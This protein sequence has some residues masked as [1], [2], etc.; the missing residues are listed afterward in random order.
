[1]R[2]LRSLRGLLPQ[3]DT[4][5]HA[6]WRRRHHAMVVL[7]FAEAVGLTLFSAVQGYGVLHSVAHVAT[8]V[9]VGIGALLL[10]HRRRIAS[11]LV[12]LG[13]ITACALL[14]HVWNGAIEA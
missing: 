3:G 12:S 7:L 8:L 6:A 9:P 10:E 11:I 13:L 2:L 5:P 14:V 1:M 4:L